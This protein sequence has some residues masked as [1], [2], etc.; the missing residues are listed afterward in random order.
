[1][2]DNVVVD[3]VVVSDMLVNDVVAK[4]VVGHQIVQIPQ[5]FAYVSL[6]TFEQRAQLGQHL[7]VKLGCQ[8]ADG[9]LQRGERCAAL[10]QRGQSSRLVSGDQQTVQ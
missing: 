9:C 5:A 10:K 3:N 1:M 7:F 4:R 8:F 6:M 2:V